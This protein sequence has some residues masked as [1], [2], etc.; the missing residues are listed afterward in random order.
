MDCTFCTE[1][2]CRLWGASAT[3]TITLR[4]MLGISQEH[5]RLIFQASVRVQRQV[6][7]YPAGCLGEPLRIKFRWASIPFKYVFLSHQQSRPPA[8]K[9]SSREG[10][11]V[12]ARQLIWDGDQV[13]KNMKKQR[14]SVEE[15]EKQKKRK[16]GSGC[17]QLAYPAAATEILHKNLIWCYCIIPYTPKQSLMYSFSVKILV[18]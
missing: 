16:K 10:I 4:G 3:L 6:G 14:K 1:R 2:Y 8:E 17:R 18:N 7:R 13:P 5:N 9:P 15:K 12:I 11:A